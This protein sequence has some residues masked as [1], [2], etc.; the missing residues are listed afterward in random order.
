MS[1]YNLESLEPNQSIDVE[2]N[3]LNS[4]RVCASVLKK[5][6]GKSFKINKTNTGAKVTRLS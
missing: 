4:L 6:H 1:K 2:S 3:D 5:K